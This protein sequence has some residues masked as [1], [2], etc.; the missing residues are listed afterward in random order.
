MAQSFNYFGLRRGSTKSATYTVKN[1]KQITKDRVTEITNQQTSLQMQ[2][3]LKIPIVAQAR[4]VLSQ[5]VDHSFEGVAY[6]EKSLDKFYSENLKKDAIT[7]TS[8]IPK[9][10]IDCGEADYIVSKGSLDFYSSADG[11]NDTAGCPFMLKNKTKPST[12]KR[13]KLYNYLLTVKDG[14]KPTAELLEWLLGAYPLLFK[15]DQ[16]T[17][18]IG[19]HKDQYSWTVGANTYKAYRHTFYVG[20][21]VLNS[22]SEIWQRWKWVVTT[23]VEDEDQPEITDTTYVLTDGYIDIK[24][25]IIHKDGDDSELYYWNLGYQ[26]NKGLVADSAQCLGTCILSRQ[27]TDKVWLRSTSKFCVVGNQKVTYDQVIDTYLKNNTAT[28]KYLNSGVDGVSITG[29]STT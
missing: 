24:I 26:V 29:G 22:E 3:R 6:G 23:E 10:A 18:L 12:V 5:I 13:N 2:Q 27:A 19:A 14:D 8:Y 17:F 15:N 21:I 11:I 20:R 7:I 9:G 25:G 28:T 4:S 16:L 1:G